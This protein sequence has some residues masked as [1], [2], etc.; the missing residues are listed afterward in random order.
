MMDICTWVGFIGYMFAL[1]FFLLGFLSILYMAYDAYKIGKNKGWFFLLNQNDL[2]RKNPFNFLLF[3]FILLIFGG[4]FFIYKI[5]FIIIPKYWV[6]L[7]I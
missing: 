1:I 2:V 3:S 4:Y 7:T 5:A 6:C